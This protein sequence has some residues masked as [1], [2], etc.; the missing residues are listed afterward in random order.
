MS[1]GVVQDSEKSKQ[2]LQHT[3]MNSR[4]DANRDQLH[5][6]ALEHSNHERLEPQRLYS[7]LDSHTVKYANFVQ[8]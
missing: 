1:I 5:H 6:Q 8:I 3:V 2:Q 4:Y 7:M